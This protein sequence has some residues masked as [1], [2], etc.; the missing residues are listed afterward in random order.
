[1]LAEVFAASQLAVD[2]GFNSTF[3]AE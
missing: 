3:A 1:M 2:F